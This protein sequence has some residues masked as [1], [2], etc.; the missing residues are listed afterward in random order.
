MTVHRSPTLENKFGPAGAAQ[1]VEHRPLHRKIPARFLVKAQAWVSG[2]IP[3]QGVYGGQLFD[4]SLS[5]HIL[6]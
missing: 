1:L 2:L 3:G 5:K 4:V 6:G